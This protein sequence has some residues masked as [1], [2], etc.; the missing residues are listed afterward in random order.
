MEWLYLI[1]PFESIAKQSRVRALA[2]SSWTDNALAQ[3]QADVFFGPLY[4]YYHPFHEAMHDE[5][6]GW[7][8]QRGTQKGKSTAVKLLIKQLRSE[9][10]KDWVRHVSVVSAPGTADYKRL[11]PHGRKRFQQGKTDDRI[12]AVKILG[13]AL[14]G[15]AALA[16]IKTDVDNF[17]AQL[18]NARS[19]QQGAQGKTKS[20]SAALTKAQ[21]EAM[22]ALYAVLGACIQQFPN[23][24]RKIKPLFD[25]SAIRNR[26]QTLFIN[27][28]AKGEDVTK[29]IFKRTVKAE[30]KVR[31]TNL[32]HHAL[33]FFVAEE[34]NDTASAKQVR[35]E[36]QEDVIV[37]AGA[38]QHS[39]RAT[40]FK[41]RNKDGHADG[42]FRIEL[43]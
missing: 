5:L 3:R 4:V 8:G 40:F 36:G 10:I 2:I 33:D 29:F 30:R 25:I 21:R 39:A 43:L 35:V 20:N 37:D 32:S 24:L 14:T 26:Q 7:K 12:E 11:F 38:I 42:H 6:I 13:E 9:K 17:Y 18:N 28:V 16:A 34:K 1:N 15:I 19:E 23:N 31:I 27:T 22:H 41:V